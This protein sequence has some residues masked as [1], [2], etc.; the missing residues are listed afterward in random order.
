M[1]ENASTKNVC[2]ERELAEWRGGARRRL[3][4]LSVEQGRC[5]MSKASGS[6]SSARKEIASKAGWG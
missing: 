2:V 1:C 5:Y 4:L 3:T 6:W